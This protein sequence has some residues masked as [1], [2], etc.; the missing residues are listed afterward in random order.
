MSVAFDPDKYY[1]LGE[2]KIAV[3]PASSHYEKLGFRFGDSPNEQQI[4]E[5]FLKRDDWWQQKDKI[6][7]SGKAHPYLKEVG[8]FIQDAIKNL[9]EAKDTLADPI[10]K[11]QYDKKLKDET[12]KET[13]EEL[14]KYI[15]FARG[16]DNQISEEEKS[17]LLNMADTLNIHRDRAEEII[18]AE[19]AKTGATFKSEG[20]GASTTASMPFDAFLN[21]THYEILGL[22]DDADYAQIKEAYHRE[23]VKYNETRDKAKA[24]ARFYVITEAWECL[25][26]PVKKREYD[27]KLKQPKTPVPTGIRLVIECKTDYTFKDIRRGTI[28]TEKIVIKN[29]KGGLLQGTIKSNVPWLEPDRDKVLEK[30]EQELHINVLTSK[31]PSKTYKSKGNIIIDTNGGKYIIPFKIFLENYEAELLRFKTVYVPLSASLFGFISSFI[32][33]PK[34]LDLGLLT[35][36]PFAIWFMIQRIIE[37]GIKDT[38]ERVKQV[39]L[40]ILI[41]W[42]GVSIASILKARGNDIPHFSGFIIGAYIFGG[43][44]YLLSRKALEFSLDRG[45]DLS[46]YPPVLIHGTSIGLVVLSI[47]SHSGSGSVIS[48]SS[49]SP[50]PFHA[51]TPKPPPAPAPKP[52][53]IK[54]ERSVIA[55]GLDSSKKPVGVNTNFSSGNK[56]LYYYVSYNGAI[57]NSTV[58]GYKWFKDGNQIRDLQ[59]QYTVKHASGNAWNSIDY[60]FEPGG[61]EARLYVNG[62]E[63]DRTFFSINTSTA[64]IQKAEEQRRQQEAERQR[65]EA[66]QNRQLEEQKRAEEQRRQR[67]A[68]RQRQNGWKKS[69]E[70]VTY[71]DQLRDLLRN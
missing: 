69:R 15:N 53:Q 17:N 19:M 62:N 32:A 40:G 18:I 5:A 61:Y 47:I 23:H 58:F 37:K 4:K 67:E 41:G 64:D 13:E 1:N 12:I 63:I 49:Y 60:N 28:L 39:G 8:P 35:A 7:R 6:S 14:I 57:A 26:D 42:I 21:K 66:E 24:S 36:I 20:A 46:K 43:L 27:E 2:W 3:N 70:G 68:E 9:R 31:I 51:P 29:T 54:V 25:R 34:L 71:E 11:A 59:F 38:F 55:E 16:G 52:P 44:T 56:R 50:S 48:K 10:K 30:H 22:T 45:I 65:R 33:G